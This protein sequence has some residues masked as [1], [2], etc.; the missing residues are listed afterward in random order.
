MD[1][2]EFIYGTYIGLDVSGICDALMT[3]KAQ[4]LEAVVSGI[5]VAAAN[6]L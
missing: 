1:T 3:R 5:T 4:S 6:Q 2:A